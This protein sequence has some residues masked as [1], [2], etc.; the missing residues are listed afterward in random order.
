MKSEI[1]E[2]YLWEKSE[3]DAEI[4]KLENLLQ[5]FALKESEA[6]ILPQKTF[7]FQPKTSKFGVFFKFAF[8][9]SVVF[10]VLVGVWFLNS[11][12]PNI[13]DEFIAENTPEIPQNVD[14]KPSLPVENLP[15]TVEKVAQNNEKVFVEKANFVKTTTKETKPSEKEVYQ[16]EKTVFVPKKQTEPIKKVENNQA[17]VVLTDEEKKA[18]ETLKLALSITGDKL[19]IVKEKIDNAEQNSADLKQKSTK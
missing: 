2:N 9:T 16:V 14:S 13:S 8:A 11:D 15:K 5:G 19:K 18:Y 12:K 1:N 3:S 17:E 4:E 6:P 7:D 10:A